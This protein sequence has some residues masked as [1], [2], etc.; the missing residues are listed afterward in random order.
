M[1]EHFGPPRIPVGPLAS[2]H[3]NRGAVKF[4]LRV[5]CPSFHYEYAQVQCHTAAVVD[6]GNRPYWSA[7]AQRPGRYHS[8]WAGRAGVVA[9]DGRKELP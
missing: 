4:L 2:Q 6:E 3:H 7:L 8:A 9:L 1:R 5:V